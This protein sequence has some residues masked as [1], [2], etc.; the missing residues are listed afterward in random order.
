M[1]TADL[2][3]RIAYAITEAPDKVAA[4]RVRDLVIETKRPSR[5]RTA[6]ARLAITDEVAKALRGRQDLGPEVL[7]VV[8]PRETCAD[9]DEAK[10]AAESPIVLPWGSK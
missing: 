4:A 3:A 9:Y 6:E 7:I 8:I 2:L 5:K 1:S 10:R